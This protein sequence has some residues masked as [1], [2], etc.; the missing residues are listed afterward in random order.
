MNQI[1]ITGDMHS[2]PRR[3]SVKSFPM[4]ETMDK[5]DVVIIAGDFGSFGKRHQTAMRAT[6]SNG[7]T[8]SHSPPCLWTEITK[9]SIDSFPIPQH[10]NS[11]D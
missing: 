4:Q 5:S 2:D 8:I 1:F 7:S 3:F 6:G 10:K 9:I 11:V